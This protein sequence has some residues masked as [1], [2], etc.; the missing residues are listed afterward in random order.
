MA[1]FVVARLLT[2]VVLF[3]AITLF[4][5]IVF[6]VLPQPQRAARSAAAAT[7]SDTTSTTRCRLHGTL[8]QQYAQFI[9]G[10][11][12]HGSLGR[13]YLNRREVTAMI[14]DAAPVTLS[15]LLGGARL[16]AADGVS[17]RD[18]LGAAAPLALR[19]RRDGVRPD[20]GVGPSRLA[21]PRAR[22]AARVPAA[23]LPV[24]RLLRVLQPADRS[25]AG[26]PSGRIT[27]SC[28]GSSS[29]CCTR[30]STRG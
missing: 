21:R 29:R 24:L 11:V 9:W 18:P 22:L 28:R 1:R 17:D 3:F 4:V 15:L 26:R 27:C 5:F 23:H 13:S 7:P 19:Q 30:R 8:P 25:A 2:S 12:R 14:F 20:R 6:F 10:L 16:L